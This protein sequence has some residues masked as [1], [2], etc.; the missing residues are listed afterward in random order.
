MCDNDSIGTVNS[1]YADSFRQ[2]MEVGYGI[3]NQCHPTESGLR[4]TVFCNKPIEW[5]LIVRAYGVGNCQRL[6]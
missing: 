4:G 2:V 1:E 5:F 6:L 3:Q